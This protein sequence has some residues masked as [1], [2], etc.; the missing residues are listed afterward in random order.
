MAPYGTWTCLTSPSLEVTTPP[1]NCGS[2]VWMVPYQI[3]R[4]RRKYP[5]EMVYPKLSSGTDRRQLS[6]GL[7]KIGKVKHDA[8]QLG[9]S[10]W[11][12]ITRRVSVSSTHYIFSPYPLRSLLRRGENKRSVK[13]KAF[14]DVTIRKSSTWC[15][16]KWINVTHVSRYLEVALHVLLVVI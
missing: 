6:F 13:I 8:E 12:Y 5:V 11:P 3:Y 4:I 14:S 1:H 15:E 9:K 10:F 7:V 16:W 2:H